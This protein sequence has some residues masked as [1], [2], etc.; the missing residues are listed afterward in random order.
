[1]KRLIPAKTFLLGEYAAVLGGPAI[2][3]TTTPCF[4]LT[5]VDE[6]YHEGIHSDSPAGQWW[7]N[8]RIPGKSLIWRDPY[9]GKGGLGASSAQFLGV[10]L[11]SCDLLHL[12]PSHKVLLDAYYQSSWRGE[13]LRPS[14]YDLL[15]QSQH[16]CVY[17]NRQQGIMHSYDW[18]FEDIAFL[19]V[20]SGQKLMTHDHLKQIG[21]P[22][23]MH[24]LFVVA[25]SAKMAFEQ[26]CSQQL[27]AAVDAY[28]Q[29]L[30]V[31]GLM[32]QSS[33]EYLDALKSNKNILTAKGCG[34]MGA[35]VL[36]LIIEKDALTHVS[37]NLIV[38]GWTVL[39]SS[40]NLY[41]GSKLL[42]NNARK[43][44]EILS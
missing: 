12:K 23:S 21:L 22:D 24:D 11:A 29:L 5:L 3:L 18:V 28:Q 14:A 26:R 9:E 38:D 36:L 6:N 15:A 17:I 8:H 34:A 7:A 44:L 33:L 32:A 4:E 16:R 39:A 19:L 41:T 2:I 13:G 10:Y 25:E 27:I 35:D 20:H 31:K 42:R 37:Q 43:I 1:M 30:T 40:Q